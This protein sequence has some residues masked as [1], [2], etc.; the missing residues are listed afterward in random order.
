LSVDDVVAAVGIERL[1]L[2]FAHSKRPLHDHVANANVLVTGLIPDVVAAPV[3]YAAIYFVHAIRRQAVHIGADCQPG[4]DVG[5]VIPPI[6]IVVVP[7]RPVVAAAVARLVVV[8]AIVGSVGSIRPAGAAIA[9]PPRQAVVD[10][11]A[12]VVAPARPVIAAA[13]GRP[14]MKAIVD[15]SATAKAAASNAT[16]ASAT[17]TATP[18]ATLRIAAVDA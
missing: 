6:V 5:R 15:V 3:R 11:G 1:H 8:V 14:M 10:M 7:A 17:A 12:T 16:A 2:D 9:R 13:A 18:A 4:V